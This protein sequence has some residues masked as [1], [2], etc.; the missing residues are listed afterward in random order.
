LYRAKSDFNHEWN[1]DEFS[2]LYELQ[3]IQ[4]LLKAVGSFASFWMLRKDRR[5]LKYIHGTMHR[6]KKSLEP[7]AAFPV[8]KSVLEDSGAYHW[9]EDKA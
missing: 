4:R 3:S 1:A 5:Y 7:L 9:T 6:V 2:E 8:I